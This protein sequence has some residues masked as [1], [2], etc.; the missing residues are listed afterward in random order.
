MEKRLQLI[1]PG[2]SEGRLQEV[3][4][5]AL[6]GVEA[7]LCGSLGEVRP[8]PL[9]FAVALDDS[10]MNRTLYAW[11]RALRGRPD[12]LSGCVGALLVDGAGELYTKSAARELVLA[13]NASG[14]AFI[15]QPLVEATGSLYNFRVRAHTQGTGLMGAYVSA[16]RGLVERLLSYERPCTASPRILTLY[17]SSRSQSNTYALFQMVKEH[18][19]QGII[20]EEIHL[21]NGSV[22]DC[23]GC[24]YTTCLHFGSRGACFYGGVIVDEVYPAILNC[25]AL[26]LLCPNYND[27]VD[28]NLTAFINRM[29]ALFRMTGFYE[30][31]LFAIIVSGYSGG[32]IV[33]SQLISALNMNKSFHLPPR[34]CMLETANDPGSIHQ[35]EGIKEK[36]EAFASALSSFLME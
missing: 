20:L 25:D 4:A 33:A 26:L 24:A 14:C 18:L 19:K 15:G 21:R 3:L 36:A 8:G 2:L 12:A 31:A 27:A 35:V 17:A 10:G 16:V 29:T 23:E 9:L 11:L 1:A 32:D 28:A 7:R 22:A 5:F 6:E 13:A 34:F 30:K